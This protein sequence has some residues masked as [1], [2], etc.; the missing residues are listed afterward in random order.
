MSLSSRALPLSIQGLLGIHPTEDEVRVK[1]L[2]PQ[3]LGEMLD[4]DGDFLR[5]PPHHAAPHVLESTIEVLG[6]GGTEVETKF[7]QLLV[8]RPWGERNL[9]G[10]RS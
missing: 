6:Q 7:V 10:F 9:Q 1:I 8:L 4:V 3:L 2:V 5:S